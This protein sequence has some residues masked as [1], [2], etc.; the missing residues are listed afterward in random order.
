MSVKFLFLL[1]LSSQKT[2]SIT[3]HKKKTF[4]MKKKKVAAVSA[5]PH[6][7]GH[8]LRAQFL[9]PGLGLTVYGKGSDVIDAVRVSPSTFKGVHAVPGQRVVVVCSGDSDVSPPINAPTARIGVLHPSNDLEVHKVQLPTAWIAAYKTQSSYPKATLFPLPGTL[10]SVAS[11]TFALPDGSPACT[12]FTPLL[13]SVLLGRVF[14]STEYTTTISVG[15]L[16]RTR[17][18]EVTVESDKTSGARYCS[19]ETK[20]EEKVMSTNID[21]NSKTL[22]TDGVSAVSVGLPGAVSDLIDTIC[23]TFSGSSPQSLGVLLYGVRGVGKTY[24]ARSIAKAT[25]W[26]TL[27]LRD[28]CADSSAPSSERI[29]EVLTG[30]IKTAGTPLCVVI[31]E[32]PSF[33]K[34][35]ATASESALL[36]QSA[37]E[38]VL[39]SSPARSVL[40]LCVADS[41]FSLG[42]SLRRVGRIGCECELSAPGN[43]AERSALFGAILREKGWP[44]EEVESIKEAVVEVGEITHGF[45][46]ADLLGVA[47]AAELGCVNGPITAEAVL[48]AAKTTRPASLK[49]HEVSVP[50]VRWD[51]VGG[52][53]EAKQVLAECVEWPLTHATLFKALDLRPPSGVLLYG[54][55][56]CSKV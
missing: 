6:S 55:P 26:E 52:Q 33:V 23:R 53:E 47:A 39:E 51:D 11:I 36:L 5:A 28:G 40:V 42:K 35:D 19:T 9:G 34:P 8:Q 14:P 31:D 15:V 46:A 17:E 37:L 29:A 7:A 25:G 20:V 30:C 54:P 43:A 41:P 3:V 50:T 56:G 44:K 12:G 1:L 24:T 10:R 22:F 21:L 38:N 49:T 32:L 48:Q 2:I 27:T 4:K 13:K 16:G 18:I 45:V